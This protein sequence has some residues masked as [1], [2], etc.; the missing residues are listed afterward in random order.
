MINYERNTQHRVLYI[1]RFT[2]TANQSSQNG[3]NKLKRLTVVLEQCVSELMEILTSKLK[4]VDQEILVVIKSLI[5][6]KLFYNIVPL[7]VYLKQ[8]I[9]AL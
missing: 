9:K 1:L 3:A 7:K 5:L 6:Y 8:Y 4:P 2:E